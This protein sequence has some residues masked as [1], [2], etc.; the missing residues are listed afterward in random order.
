MGVERMRAAN[1]RRIGIVLA[2]LS[3]LLLLLPRAAN[4]DD[5]PQWRGPNRNGISAEKGWL[6]DWPEQGPKK[7]W[8]ASLGAGCSSV[9]V[10]GDR[11]FTMG[12]VADKESVYCLGAETGK[13][14]WKYEYDCPLNPKNFEGGPGTTPTIYDN[15]VYS[16]SRSGHLHCLD[17]DSGSLVWKKEAVKELGTQE[18]T[19]GLTCSPYAFGDKVVVNLDKVIAFKKDTGETL[20]QTERIGAGYSTPAEIV[21]EGKQYLAVFGTVG[22]VVLDGDSGKE[23]LRFP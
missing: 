17:A 19:W 6:T 8:S 1:N 15:R 14:I 22:L 5:W 16:L 18:P 13:T 7:L 21:L 20:W 23:L 3:G 11:V 2:V 12:N 9:S 4:A 10:K